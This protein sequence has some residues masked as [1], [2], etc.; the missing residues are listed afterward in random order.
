MKQDRT[1]RLLM[2]RLCLAWMAHGARR[3]PT[4]EG[5]GPTV[6]FAPHF[7]DEV[8]A[9]GGT[10]IKK[11]RA[12]APVTVVFMTDGSKSHRDFVDGATLKAI[13]SN[14]AQRAAQVLGL[15]SSEVVMLGH[16]EMHLAD[17]VPEAMGQV[18][19]LLAALRPA[20]VFV[21][22]RRE[23]H[24]DHAATWRIIYGALARS[25]ADVTLYEY[26]VWLWHNWPWVPA[27]GSTWR[28]SLRA[29][30]AG[31]WVFLGETHWR[32]AVW[33]VLETKR[34]ALA[35][36]KSQTTRMTLDPRWP[37]LSDVGDGEFLECFFAGSEFF[38]RTKRGSTG[39]R[40]R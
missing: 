14:E 22:S 25:S 26:P 16:E 33:D 1:F 35:Q 39:N 8:L 28:R 38:A 19:D 17:V 2:R 23:P 40:T 36:Y 31:L 34:S 6:V 21:P 9:C 20:E 11:K 5:A 30:L 29:A 27:S 7:D 10:I 3:I 4:D 13:R 12:G 32:I 18:A 37:I 15:G 24:V